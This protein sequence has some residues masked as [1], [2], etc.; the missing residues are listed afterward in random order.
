MFGLKPAKEQ[1]KDCGGTV[2]NLILI[3]LWPEPLATAL[4]LVPM[5][6]PVPPTLRSGV[7]CRQSSPYHQA[8]VAGLLVLRD[9]DEVV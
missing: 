2:L 8:A 4:V 6:V 1:V 5:R 3:V 9:A 7:R